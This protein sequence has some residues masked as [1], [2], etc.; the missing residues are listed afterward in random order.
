LVLQTNGTYTYSVENS[1][2]QYLNSGQFKTETF[3][4]TS[5]DGT[6][7][8]ISFTIYGADET[9]KAAPPVV[10]GS[11][12]P[13]DTAPVG[14]VTTATNQGEVLKGT[15]NNDSL[16]GL[17]G[18]DTIYGLAG[19]DFIFGSQGDDTI[20]GGSGA[21][22]INGGEGSDIIIGGLGA[23]L[24]T[25]YKG[26][27]K[28]VFLDFKDTGDTITDFDVGQ[29][30]IAFKASLGVS[31]SDLIFTQS[32]GDTIV[33]VDKPG[34]STTAYEMQFTLSGL[35]SLSTADFDFNW[36]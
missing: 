34:G 33:S 8:S 5:V 18:G 29:D 27:D 25:G 28:F 9:I 35:K 16:D 17:Q 36:V 1:A 19:N 26:A 31:F 21:D 11:S 24:L 30:K 2:A 10:T 13:N 20:Y 32:N 7:K 22:T 14:A 12:D 6:T 23:D 15:P 4:V 3:T